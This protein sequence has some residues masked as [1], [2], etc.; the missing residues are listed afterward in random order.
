MTSS[1]PDVW[2]DW[3]SPD[4]I[5]VKF[6]PSTMLAPCAHQPRDHWKNMSMLAGSSMGCGRSHSSSLGS[7]CKDRHWTKYGLCIANRK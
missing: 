1:E 5:A 4:I 6:R 3:N 7:A 2:N